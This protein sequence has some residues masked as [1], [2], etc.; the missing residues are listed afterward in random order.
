MTVSNY[1][2]WSVPYG[3]P[4]YTYSILLTSLRGKQNY[5]QGLDAEADDFMS[6]PLDPDLMEAQLRVAERSLGLRYEVEQLQNLL[7]ICSYCK[8]IRDAEDAWTSVENYI[9]GQT[10]ADFTHSICPGCY[11]TV[12]QPELEQL[13]KRCG[14]HPKETGDTQS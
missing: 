4:Q 3:V 14:H 8:K 7:P 13:K 6:K 1:A 9:A 10:G 11:N 12:V 5:L 2:A